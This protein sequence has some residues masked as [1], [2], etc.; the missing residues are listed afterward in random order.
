MLAGAAPARPADGSAVSRPGVRF[1]LYETVDGG[2]SWKHVRR[3]FPE[4]LEFDTI[5]DIRY[6]PA[7]T[8]NAI[9]AL[10]SGEL[11]RTRNGGDWWEPIG[12]RSRRPECSAPCGSSPRLRV[13]RWT[14]PHPRWPTS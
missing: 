10:D 9:V 14:G 2:K 13:S 3:G 7:A 4:V 5:A 11:W 1:S 12:A 8:E 6:D